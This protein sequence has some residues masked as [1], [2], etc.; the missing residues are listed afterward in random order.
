MDRNQ[1]TGLFL[2]SALLLV[3]LFFFSPKTEPEKNKT[4]PTTTTAAKVAVPTPGLAPEAKPDTAA[5]PVRSIEL[6]N[7]EL[8]LNFSTQGGRVVAVRLNKY[9][10]FFGKPLDLFDAQSARFNTKF[11]TTG[12][13]TIDFAGLNFSAT[14]PTPTPDGGQQL[15]FTAPVGGGTVTQTY[16]VPK[17]GYEVKYN[18]KL[19]GVAVAQEPLTF[20]F[21]DNVRQTEQDLKQ[22]RNHTTINHYLATDDPGSLAEAS[23]KPEEMKIAT[24]I[25]W[26]ADKH[27]FFVAGFIADS[28]PFANGTFN[29]TVDL[30][31]STFIKRLSTTLALPVADVTSAAGGQYRF[32]FGPNQFNLLKS[33]APNFDRNVYLGW[34]LFRWVNR[35]VVLPVFNFL[36]QYITSYGVIILLLVV[37]IKLVTW[38][39]TYK[40]YESQ[41]RM[42]VL[43]PELDE[44]KAK[45]PDDQVKTQQETMKLYQQF[46][47]SPL[48]GCVPTLLTLPILF[49]MFQFFPNAIELRQQPFLWAPDLST[50]DN[51]IHLPFTL[52]YLG[53]HISIFT[54]LMT[55]STLFMTYQ[56]NQMNTAAMQGP[57]KF[58]S[59]L[60]P[61]IFFFVLNSFA[62]GLTWYYLV[63]NLVTLGQQALTRS[64]VNDTKIRAQLE[65]N[66]VKNKD[67]KPGGFQARLAEAMKTAQERDAQAKKPGK[68]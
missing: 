11:R 15:A 13:Q 54:V 35:F 57:M 20:T 37:I 10:T 16:T 41:A 38:P 6:K 46:G 61:L 23:E 19:N 56:S 8:T 12:G 21:Q 24:P 52:P 7:P 18:L 55:I 47:V 67:K 44:I 63:S 22:N 30:A 14:E 32:F 39:L 17:A 43:K 68:A 34:G 48:S 64:F 9:K 58:Y 36:E 26:A 5:G 33:V 53:S 29:S 3:Y 1:A 51:A 4:Q 66:K 40:T 28:Q 31:D 2:I 60:M 50:Y 42:K 65:A 25:K 49:A 27:D 45:H 62:S 59:Y